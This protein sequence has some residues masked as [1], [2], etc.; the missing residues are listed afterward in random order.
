MEWGPIN[1]LIEHEGRVS[2]FQLASID[3]EGAKYRNIQR[4]ALPHGYLM[5][6]D[7]LPRTWEW[8]NL[9]KEQ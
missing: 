8:D 3:R 2:E 6:S 1:R 4:L 5:S 9:D 7:C